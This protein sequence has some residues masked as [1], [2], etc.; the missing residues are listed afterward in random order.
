MPVLKRAASKCWQEQSPGPGQ[1]ASIQH[2]HFSRMPS[3]L[4]CIPTRFHERYTSKEGLGSSRE[5]RASSS[6]A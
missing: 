2:M 4:G 3:S 5:V 1:H 6:P